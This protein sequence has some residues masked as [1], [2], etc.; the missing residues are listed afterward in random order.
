MCSFN[1]VDKTLESNHYASTSS[2]FVGQ[3]YGI[4]SIGELADKT[5]MPNQNAKT[6]SNLIGQR[7]GIPSVGE[8]DQADSNTEKASLPE[9]ISSN[10]NRNVMNQ[11]PKR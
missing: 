2:N 1:F 11:P 9:L 8:L 7:Y 5:F 3:R 4:P 10:G 6:P